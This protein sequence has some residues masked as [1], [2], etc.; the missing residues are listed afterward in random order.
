MYK[1]YNKKTYHKYLDYLADKCAYKEKETLSRSTNFEQQ[2]LN[3]LKIQEIEDNFHNRDIIESKKKS[4]KL[5]KKYYNFCYK[6]GYRMYE[7]GNFL[8][9][10]VCNSYT[11]YNTKFTRDIEYKD[12][13]IYGES[14][15]IYRF[16]AYF[17]HN[18]ARLFNIYIGLNNVIFPWVMFFF[19]W[20]LKDMNVIVSII[21]SFISV[22]LLFNIEFGHDFIGE[23]G[24][25]LVA[26]LMSIGT[27]FLYH[28]YRY[29]ITNFV[30]IKTLPESQQKDVILFYLVI[31]FAVSFYWNHYFY[32]SSRWKSFEAANFLGTAYLNQYLQKLRWN[33]IEKQ[34]AIFKEDLIKK[35]GE[36]NGN[37]VYENTK[38]EMFETFEVDYTEKELKQKRKEDRQY[39]KELKKY[40]NS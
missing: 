40:L 3:Q 16:K 13:V 23:I 38:Y 30:D 15:F 33:Y 22:A 17:G 25:K 12:A 11:K 39:K 32:K 31:A 8:Y 7:K 14:S 28:S 19:F 21:L 9:K 4:H 10:Y 37:Y 29:R 24:G 2:M 1:E 5:N 36:K 26:L 20:A 35:Y 27:G 34:E 18:L 6:R